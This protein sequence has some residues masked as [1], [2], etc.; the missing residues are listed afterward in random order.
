MEQ[1][2]C[3]SIYLVDGEWLEW[4]NWEPCSTTCGKGIKKRTRICIYHGGK[5]CSADGSKNVEFFTCKEASCPGW[6]MYTSVI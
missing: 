5:H 3:F 4:E 2:N 6:S 1:S